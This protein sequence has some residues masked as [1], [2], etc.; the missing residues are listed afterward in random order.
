MKRNTF[1]IWLCLGLLFAVY[2]SVGNLKKKLIKHNAITLIF[3]F[4][5]IY[6][7]HKRRKDGFKIVHISL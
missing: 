6:L 3:A 7:Y 2:V 4:N 5:K 1:N